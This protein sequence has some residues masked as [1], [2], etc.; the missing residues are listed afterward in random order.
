MTND[1]WATERAGFLAA[2]GLLSERAALAYDMA[3]QGGTKRDRA[4]WAERAECLQGEVERL[5]IIARER[6]P[7]RPQ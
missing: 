5:V 4:R 3:R 2:A 7:E 6:Y 1:A